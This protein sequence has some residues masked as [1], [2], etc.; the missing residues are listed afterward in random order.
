MFRIGKVGLFT[1]L[2]LIELILFST[3]ITQYDQETIPNDSTVIQIVSDK[4]NVNKRAIFSKLRTVAKKENYQLTL[5]RV[6]RLNNHVTKSY[7]DFNPAKN[8][9][10]SLFK[11]QNLNKITNHDLQLE[12][13]RGEYFTNASGNSL[14][15]LGSTLDKL[16]IK[17]NISKVSLFDQIRNDSST[18]S[19]LPIFLSIL[20]ILL[21]VM[22]MEKVSNFKK[23]AILKLNGWTIGQILKRDIKSNLPLFV[24]VALMIELIYLIY[25]FVQMNFVGLVITLKYSLRI[26]VLIAILIFFLDLISYLALLL[27]NLYS[28]IKGNSSAKSL[29]IVGYVLKGALLILVSINIF[30]KLQI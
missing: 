4:A 8:H 25:N 15:N 16:G 12:D 30:G 27:M 3:I 24:V 26:I 10:F 2:T 6:N 17:Y 11:T 1:L 7:Y 29:T 21:I 19:Y 28:A 20:G 13:I 23:Y 22:F 9:V 18:T 5:V 14:E